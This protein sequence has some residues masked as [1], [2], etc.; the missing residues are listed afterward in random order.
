[1]HLCVRRRLDLAALALLVLAALTMVW[2]ALDA[3]R[4]VAVLAALAVVPG[5]ALVAFLPVDSILTWVVAATLLSLCTQT[6]LGLLLLWARL[7]HPELQGL[8]VGVLSAA[9]LTADL[10]RPWR[11][12]VA[13]V[14]AKLS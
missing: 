13:P 12:A 14:T 5:A 3:V 11:S 8:V 6:L 9:V 2:P 7:W 10:L 4:P 1:M